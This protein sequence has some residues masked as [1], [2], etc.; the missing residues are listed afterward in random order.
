[1]GVDRLQSGGVEVDGRQLERIDRAAEEARPAVDGIGG[2][3]PGVP[4]G[5][6]EAVRA[7]GDDPAVG[8]QRALDLLREESA[9]GFPRLAAR[10][11]ALEEMLARPVED[12]DVSLPAVGG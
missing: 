5:V 8:G 9:E 1:R 6:D 3:D 7:G 4:E 11:E 10:R 12:G 2:E